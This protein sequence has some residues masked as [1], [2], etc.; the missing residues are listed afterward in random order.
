MPRSWIACLA[1]LI[2]TSVT[3][4][5]DW[6]Q[7]RGADRANRSSETGLFESWGPEGPTLAWIADG[8]GKGYASVS[9]SGD[10]IYT[11][12]NFDNDQSVVAVDA[13]SGNVLWKQPIT[14]GPPKHGYDGS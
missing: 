5:E 1:L 2:S 8:M 3:L 6:P 14:D 13:S 10:R 7:W 9:V 4:A 11:S 12:G